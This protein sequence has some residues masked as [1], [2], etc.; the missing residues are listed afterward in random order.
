MLLPIE[1]AD[2]PFPAQSQRQLGC[3]LKFLRLSALLCMADIG[4][5]AVRLSGVR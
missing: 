3:A 2:R 4:I 1:G 5:P